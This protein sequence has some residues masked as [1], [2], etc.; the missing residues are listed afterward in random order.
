MRKV[1]VAFAL[2]ACP[3]AFANGMEIFAKG[4]VSKNF[5][6]R[7]TYTISVSATAGVAFT[8][9]PRVRLEG[10][11]TNISS[12]Q[13]KLDIGQPV[14]LGTIND[15]KTQTAIY[16]LGIDIDILGEKSTFQPFIYLG[17]GYLVT[18][19]SY[20]FTPVSGTATL[21]ADPRRDG[22]SGNVGAGFRIRLMRSLAF[23]VEVFGYAMDVDQ[24]NP[25]IN[26]FGT[27]GIRIFI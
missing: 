16:S 21:Y 1:L 3:V 4:S 25:L 7:D 26:L 20:Y 2:M 9:I 24:P 19:R 6:D 22:F 23:E 15:M 13:N 14:V 12:L 27:V 5:I 18:E 10:R 17:G 8:L 11:Y